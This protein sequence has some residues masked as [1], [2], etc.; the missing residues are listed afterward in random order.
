MNI[1]SKIENNISDLNERI[2]WDEYFM[3]IAL[4]VSSRSACNRLH[5]GCVIVDNENHIV[6]VGYN[7]FLAGVPHTSR[8]RNNHEQSTV[9]A[10]QNAISYAAKTGIPVKDCT[11][12]I[13][14]YPCIN[15]AKIL[16]AS[17]IKNIYFHKDYK[18]DPMVS[19]ILQDAHINLNKI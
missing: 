3:S 6:S 9:H 5:V 1:I 4:L 16:A 11:A 15:C 14:H 18:N 7:G 17:G 19:E 13:T 8:I 10:E 12:Y 2:T